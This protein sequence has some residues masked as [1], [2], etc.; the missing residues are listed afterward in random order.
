[1]EAPAE[2]L[3]SLVKPGEQ[4]PLFGVLGDLL[5]PA[6]QGNV[7]ALDIAPPILSRSRL[8]GHRVPFHRWLGTGLAAGS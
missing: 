4:R 2:N 6:K 8:S 5:D 1:M 7:V 3:A